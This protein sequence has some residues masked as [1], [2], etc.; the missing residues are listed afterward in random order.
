MPRKQDS[1]RQPE[2]FDA[3]SEGKKI[4]I[5]AAGDVL[6]IGAGHHDSVAN[7]MRAQKDLKEGELKKVDVF[8]RDKA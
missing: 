4:S 6:V 5:T 8:G 2:D 7:S 1:G 3:T